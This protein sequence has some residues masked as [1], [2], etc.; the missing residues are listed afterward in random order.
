MRLPIQEDFSTI[1]EFNIYKWNS[2]CRRCDISVPV[3][4]YYFYHVHFQSIGDIPKLDSVLADKYS[5]IKEKYDKSQGRNVIQIVCPNCGLI[6]KTRA[7]GREIRRRLIPE[8]LDK[9]RDSTIPNTLAVKDLKLKFYEQLGIE[10]K[11]SDALREIEKI[12]G[13]TLLPMQQVF[14]FI[15]GI[16]IENGELI[17]LGLSDCLQS[18][19]EI[20]CNLTDLK[21]LNLTNNQFERIPDCF[22]NLKHLEEL[23]LSRTYLDP[24]PEIITHIKSL[25]KLRARDFLYPN[26]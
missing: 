8:G 26:Y 12:V 19:P 10:S 24:F 20:L 22:K 17:G 4:S 16:I 9:I 5:C 14:L 11:Q 15:S 2:G 3:A 13:F 25:K 23:D 7:I 21:K 1:K 18:F 6:M